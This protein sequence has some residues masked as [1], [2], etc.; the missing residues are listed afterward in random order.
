M[1]GGT[2]GYNWQHGT[3]VFGLEGDLD[4]ANISGTGTSILWPAG[5]SSENTWLGTAR[6]GYAYDRWMPYITAGAK[7]GDGKATHPGFVGATNTQLGWPPAAA[8]STPSPATGPPRSNISTTTSATSIAASPA[9]A[10]RPP[11]SVKCGRGA[12]R[13]QLSVLTG[14]KRK[15]APGHAARGVSS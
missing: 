14:L 11:M 8:S 9:A 6:L 1:A 4:W 3:W 10:L 2:T 13:R 15:N 7:F 12:G 5:C